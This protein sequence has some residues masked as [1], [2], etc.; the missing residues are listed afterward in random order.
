MVEAEFIIRELH[1]QVRVLQSLVRDLE[2]R[3]PWRIEDDTGLRTTLREVIKHL[4]GMERYAAQR[5]S[6]P[7]LKAVWLN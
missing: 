3:Q 7:G 5:T 2:S 4:K 1:K 6:L